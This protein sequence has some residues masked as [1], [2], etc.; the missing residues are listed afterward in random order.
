MR[1]VSSKENRDTDTNT[2]EN[3]MKNCSS[4]KMTG[5]QSI[6]GVPGSRAGGEQVRK[7]LVL[8]KECKF[9]PSDSGICKSGEWY[10]YLDTF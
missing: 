4:L 6:C 9:H 7:S 10:S 1:A 3:F 5:V 2:K 8:A